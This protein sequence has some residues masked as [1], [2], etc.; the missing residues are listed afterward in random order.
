MLIFMGE[1][2]KIFAHMQSYYC[3]KIATLPHMY[4]NL[5]AFMFWEWVE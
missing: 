3:T 1:H 2:I 4:N 5:I